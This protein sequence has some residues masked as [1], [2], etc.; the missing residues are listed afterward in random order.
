MASEHDIEFNKRSGETLLKLLERDAIFV[1]DESAALYKW[2]FATLSAANTSGVLASVALSKMI[3]AIALKTAIGSFLAGSALAV[4][5]AL[6]A[7]AY[8]RYGKPNAGGEMP[9]AIYLAVSGDKT[10]YLEELDKIKNRGGRWKTLGWKLVAAVGLLSLLAFV[11]G[12][13]TLFSGLPSCE[14]AAESCAPH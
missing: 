9:H 14:L 7:L 5:T 1:E 2:L 6:G 11:A 13:V 8:I 4:I 10:R 3:S 12:G